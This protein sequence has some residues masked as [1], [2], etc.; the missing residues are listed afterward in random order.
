MRQLLSGA[1]AAGAFVAALYFLK[2]WRRS[3]DRLFA[4][5]GAAFGLLAVNN[6]ALGLTDPESEI[7]VYLYS[8]RLAAFVLIL[9]A[10]VDKN[11]VRK[12]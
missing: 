7:R 12:G 4:F 3:A 11:R 6:V 10:I 2:F 8:I 1:I 5:F 9:V